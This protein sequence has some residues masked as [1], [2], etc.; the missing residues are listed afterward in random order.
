MLLAF[1]LYFRTINAGKSRRNEDQAVVHVGLI[2]RPIKKDASGARSSS[3]S[4]TSGVKPEPVVNGH[5]DI[6]DLLKPEPSVHTRTE[7]QEHTVLLSPQGPTLPANPATEFKEDYHHTTKTTPDDS[8][9][10]GDSG[11]H[12]ISIEKGNT[13][14]H[15]L[16]DKSSPSPPSSAQSSESL[17][18]QPSS[19]QLPLASSVSLPYYLFGVFD[20]HAGWGAAV[21]AANQLHHI[22]HV[23]LTSFCI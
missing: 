21:A 4:K 18:G 8:S 2:T 1:V 23:S 14:H 20:G 6:I 17:Q 12:R 7:P 11:P 15:P 10:G 16:A 13:I 9:S 22:I 19:S 5:D 3:Q